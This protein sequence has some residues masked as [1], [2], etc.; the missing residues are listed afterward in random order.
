[1]K[2]AQ[3]WQDFMRM[4]A[5]KALKESKG[6]H[7]CKQKYIQE[8]NKM[9]WYD[10][11]MLTEASQDAGALNAAN[12]SDGGGTAFVTGETAQVGAFTW[13]T[14]LDGFT[15]SAN[16]GI[17]V[18]ATQNKTDFSAGHVESRKKIL[19]ALVTGSVMAD[20]GGLS[21]T[22]YDVVVTASF[23]VAG[24]D[25][26]AESNSATGSI[27]NILATAVA[28]QGATATLGGFTNTLAPNALLSVATASGGT[29]FTI[30]NAVKG[31][32]SAWS[33]SAT[34]GTGSLAINTLGNDT[35][36]DNRAE[37]DRQIFNGNALPYSNMPR[38]Y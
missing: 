16:I 11:V 21:S 22:G 24:A 8:Q 9:M 2:Y 26:A 1:M 10:P 18:H 6:I 38:K 37:G 14:T 19:L 25:V 3:S 32:V 30:T 12:A 23:D 28:N 5:N 36:Y 7:A 34:S 33:T 4:P 29:S 35:F 20:L 31:S 17:T 27:G 15:S 13:A